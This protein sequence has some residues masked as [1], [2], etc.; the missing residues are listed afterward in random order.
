MRPGPHKLRVGPVKSKGLWELRR[1]RRKVGYVRP[2]RMG[3]GVGT[4]SKEYY[5][6]RNEE[7]GPLILIQSGGK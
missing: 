5:I 7:E 3:F 1:G 2:P 4:N 6:D